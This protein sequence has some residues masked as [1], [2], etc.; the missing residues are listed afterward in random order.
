M[1][2]KMDATPNVAGRGTTSPPFHEHLH[3]SSTL[4]RHNG[5]DKGR[6]PFYPEGS[7]IF[8]SFEMRAN[9]R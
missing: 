2:V 1:S 5:D 9:M 4:A 6:D 7:R 8:R 3:S